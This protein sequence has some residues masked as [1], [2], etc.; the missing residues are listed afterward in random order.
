WTI[1]LG[2]SLSSTRRW[3]WRG[4]T[5]LDRAR[6]FALAW[7]VVPIV[8]FSFSGSKLAAYILPALPAVAVLAGERIA[9]F[10]REQ[11]GQRVLRVTGVL[12]I[13]IAAAA[14][15]YTHRQAGLRLSM[16]GLVALPLFLTGAVAFA[17]PRRSVFA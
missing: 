12:M 9:C 6:V 5:S 15:W 13:V 17:R 4:D 14:L 7:L 16:T 11:R 1:V 3:N 10:W 2:A 8:F